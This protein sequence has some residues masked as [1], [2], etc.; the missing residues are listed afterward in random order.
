MQLG[1]LFDGIGGFPY[2]AQRHGITPVWASEIE[3][4]CISI[5]KRHFPNMR[6]LGDITQINGAEIEPVDIITFG[7]PCQDLSV[8]GKRAGLDGEQSGL[9]NH[10]IR[11]INE[12][13]EKLM[14]NTQNSQSGKTSPARC[15]AMGDWILKPCWK[16][17]DK[18]KCQCLNMVNGQP[19][20]WLDVL[21][22]MLLGAFWTPN[23]GE[24]P[25]AAVESSLS[26]ILEVNVPP[27]YYL[28]PKAC[29]GIL[30]RAERRGKK[31]PEALEMA[32]MAHIKGA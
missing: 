29:E 31:L 7:S 20:E 25:S 15:Q 8:A 6:H 9:F 23:I 30:R 21:E 2:S 19:P 10:A 5:T 24:S 22:L 1:S 14:E 18:V 13:R 16:R 4:A 12:M 3:P 27:K 32:L 28:S 11:I 17:S 26:R